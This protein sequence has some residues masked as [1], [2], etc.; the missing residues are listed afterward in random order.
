[1]QFYTI[2]G[3][4]VWHFRVLILFYNVSFSCVAVSF[5]SIAVDV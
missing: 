3:Y 5:G 1:L 4:V 2:F